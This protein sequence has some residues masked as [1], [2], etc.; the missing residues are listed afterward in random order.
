LG[1]VL[2][3]YEDVGRGE[4]GTEEDNDE[5]TVGG[6]YAGILQADRRVNSTQGRH[7]WV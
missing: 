5:E 7:D 2:S 3:E 1:R 6:I 4:N